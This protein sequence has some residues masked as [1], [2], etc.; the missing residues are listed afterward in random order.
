MNPLLFTHLARKTCLSTQLGIKNSRFP[1][2]ILNLSC[3]KVVAGAMIILSY[4][5]LVNPFPTFLLL[6]PTLS[7]F[8]TR[9]GLINYISTTPASNNL[10]SF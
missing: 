8:V 9:I 1:A 4:I 5:I 6:C 7:S 3:P 10:T 2:K